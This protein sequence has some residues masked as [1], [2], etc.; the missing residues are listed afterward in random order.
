M[1]DR[2]WESK[3]RANAQQQQK[4]KPSTDD[5]FYEYYQKLSKKIFENVGD[6]EA[7]AWLIGSIGVIVL[8]WYVLGWWGLVALVLLPA[9][10]YL[11]QRFKPKQQT[12]LEFVRTNLQ[13]GKINRQTAIGYIKKVHEEVKRVQRDITTGLKTLDDEDTPEFM[14]IEEAKPLFDNAN[15]VIA[16]ALNS[17]QNEHVWQ[18][19]SQVADLYVTV[20]DFENAEPL[21]RQVTAM[22]RRLHGEESEAH[23]K[24][25]YRFARTA[26]ECHKLDIAEE[27][28][29]SVT[30]IVK[31]SAGEGTPDHAM[32]LNNTAAMFQRNNEHKRAAKYR[33]MATKIMEGSVG[34]EHPMYLQSLSQAASQH[35]QAEEFDKA[36][37]KFKAV[38]SALA[39][40]EAKAES[41]GQIMPPGF[42]HMKA[43]S[44]LNLAHMYCT[45]NKSQQ[46]KGKGTAK[47]EQAKEL[48]QQSIDIMEGL[49]DSDRGDEYISVLRTMADIH[50]NMKQWPETEVIFDQVLE[51]ILEKKGGDSMHYAMTMGDKG[52]VLKEQ[53]KVEESAEAFRTA[54]KAVEKAA[55]TRNNMHFVSFTTHE[56]L[57]LQ[58]NKKYDEA[59]K[60][61]KLAV[62]VCTKAFGAQHPDTALACQ[63]LAKCY[64][65]MKKF[66]K[67]EPLFRQA[68]EVLARTN[69]PALV[70]PAFKMMGECFEAA[71]QKDKAKQMFDHM[72]QLEIQM[73]QSMQAQARGASTKKSKSPNAKRAFGTNKKGLSPAAGSSK[74]SSSKKKN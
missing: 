72:R 3:I 6:K 49:N 36:E 12:L 46:M 42:L 47:F 73:S 59:E 8:M 66:S 57:V 52:V 18:S 44:I 27:L 13:Q 71:G 7:W 53:G 32:T 39:E 68:V 4:A 34:K 67:A 19:L 1:S 41:E 64:Q 60:A 11:Y 55:K 56:G 65:D 31:V 16:T 61:F 63:K 37:E 24:Y 62:E 69:I 48:C 28:L 54:A 30:E 70:L 51:M 17:P 21:M 74:K 10:F 29:N 25:V 26:E 43:V 38:I 50:F 5:V 2:E 33:G 9:M 35:E 40:H 58:E 14:R 15:K 20:G 45:M 23:V 22:L